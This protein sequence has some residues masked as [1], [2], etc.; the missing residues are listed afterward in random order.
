[1][2]LVKKSAR[3]NILVV[4]VKS[5][6]NLGFSEGDIKHFIQGVRLNFSSNQTDKSSALERTV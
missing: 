6:S 1:M 5:S 2:P 4:W 3:S